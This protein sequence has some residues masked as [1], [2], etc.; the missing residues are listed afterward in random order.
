MYS[1]AYVNK[2][3]AL[4]ATADGKPD[5]EAGAEVQVH[6]RPPSTATPFSPLALWAIFHVANQWTTVHL[7]GSIL[8]LVNICPV[9]GTDHTCLVTPIWPMHYN[10]ASQK[11]LLSLSSDSTTEQDG[12]LY[13]CAGPQSKANKAVPCCLCYAV[14]C[15]LYLTC[16][17]SVG[18]AHSFAVATLWGLLG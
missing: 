14:L 8:V 5:S 6:P 12:A 16:C 1:Q 7:H 11:W 18:N 15:R 4:L 3:A 10:V 13:D 9:A 17:Y 2:L